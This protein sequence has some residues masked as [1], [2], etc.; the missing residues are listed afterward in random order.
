MSHLPSSTQLP[1]SG[2][3]H[4]VRGGLA[5]LALTL[6]LSLATNAFGIVAPTAVDIQSCATEYIQIGDEALTS[7]ELKAHDKAQTSQAFE[8]PAAAK[9]AFLDAK[10]ASSPINTGASS[11]ENKSSFSTLSSVKPAQRYEKVTDIASSFKEQTLL[12]ISLSNGQ[13]IQATAGHPFKTLEGWRD[14]VLLKKGGQLL[15]GGEA[16]AAERYATI[17]EIR[18]EVKTTAVFNLEVANLHT[19]FVGVDGVVVHNGHGNSAASTS[20][21]V[22]YGIFNVATNATQKYGITGCAPNKSGGYRRP[23]SQLRPGENYRIKESFPSGSDARRD[24]LGAE[25]NAVQNHRD[26]NGD[27]RPPRQQRP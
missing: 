11:Y 22:L 24:A 4:R 12:H 17:L 10:S 15:V 19:F 25:R 7:G 1:P 14:A 27:K 5:L 21:Q 13:T 8:S 2:R 9:Q 18:E 6:S 26:S 23:Q 20:A 16:D 3:L